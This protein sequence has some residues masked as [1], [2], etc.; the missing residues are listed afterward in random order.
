ML[1]ERSSWK[2]TGVFILP[3]IDSLPNS[4]KKILTLKII[5]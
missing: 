1:D 2:D 3:N 4:V 5:K